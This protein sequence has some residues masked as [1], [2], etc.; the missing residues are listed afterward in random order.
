MG[1]PGAVAARA[2][3]A[4]A[5]LSSFQLQRFGDLSRELDPLAPITPQDFLFKGLL[6][7]W[8]HSERG[9]RTLDEGIRRRDSV[10]ARATRL[11][12]R[13]IR[14]MVTGRV[15]DAELALEDA[16]VAQRMLPGNALVLARSVFAH[17]VAAGAY[18]AN[19]RP[20]DGE[21]VLELARA[22]VNRPK[23]LLLDEPLAF[24]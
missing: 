11:E 1:E 14:A 9:L 22:L 18:E 15:E 21:R 2:M 5:Y 13:A 24:C 12:A 3:L 8:L 6:E 23:L 7:M 17:L 19:G 4:L 20:K 10:L 16:Q